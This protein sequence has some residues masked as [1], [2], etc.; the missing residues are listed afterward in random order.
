MKFLL[1]ALSV[2]SLLLPVIPAFNEGRKC[3]NKSGTCRK[4][5]KDGEEI[6]EACKNHRI[7]C[8]PES[9]N[10]SPEPCCKQ[11]PTTTPSNWGDLQTGF[12]DLIL[13]MPSM[14]PF[15]DDGYE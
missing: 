1:M 7:C 15:E 6:K 11:L 4:H 13:T 12:F 2:F 9:R 14:N 3:L 5:C 8:I 10:R